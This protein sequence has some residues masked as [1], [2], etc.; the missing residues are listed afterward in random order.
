MNAQGRIRV[1]LVDDHEMVRFGL[2][3]YI[4][5]SSDI[6]LCGEA[7]DGEEA[8]QMC[9]EAQP[10]V[11]LMDMI[12]PGM[13]GIEAIRRIH[14]LYPKIKIIAIT[15]FEDENLV[16]DALQA[17]AASY[18]Q[19]NIPM[20]E[21][22][23]AIRK[24]YAGKR[25]ISPEATQALIH[26]ASLDEVEINLTEREMDVLRLMVDGRS[27]PGIADQL[28]IS[29]NTVATHVSSILTKLGVRSRT[30]AVAMALKKG[31]I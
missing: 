17:G 2:S 9:A 7:S 23:E 20:K 16:Q 27:N 25:I 12:M 15:S 6:E 26:G 18:L 5:T 4:R 14:P 24:T 31:M 22:Q 1:M 13:G 8:V 21:L 30:E 29:R 11:I 3:A 19:K 10:D 28:V